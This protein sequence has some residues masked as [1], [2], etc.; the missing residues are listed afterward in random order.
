MLPVKPSAPQGMPRPRWETI[1]RADSSK[2]F[3][4]IKPQKGLARFNA[5]EFSLKAIF[6]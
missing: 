6:I 3:K 2:A 1:S 4:K 5:A